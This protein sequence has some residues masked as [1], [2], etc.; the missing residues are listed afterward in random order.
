MAS[1]AIEFHQ[2]LP[3]MIQ[4]RRLDEIFTMARAAR[5]LRELRGDHGLL[6]GEGPNLRACEQDVTMRELFDF[7]P[8][9]S[10][11]PIKQR[12]NKRAAN[13]EDIWATSNDF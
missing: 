13:G 3:A 6:P 11:L 12:N 2:Q 5:G 1:A 8:V 9:G 10:N 4:P 7:A